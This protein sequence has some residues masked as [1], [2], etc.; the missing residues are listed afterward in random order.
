M[1][2]TKSERFF[3]ESQKYIPGGVNS[4]VRSFKAVEGI[5]PFLSKGK[6]SR[7]WDI[8]DNEYIDYVCSWGPLVLG[9]AHPKI[10]E[11]L[12]ETVCNGTS[13]GAPTTLE[14][15][16][17]KIICDALPSVDTI[18]L[19]SSGTEACM[20]AIR[21]AR[22]Y[23]GKNKLIK[24]SGCYHGHS[25]GLLVKAGSGAMTHGIPTS[26]GVPESYAQETLIAE[27]NDIESVESLFND[28]PGQIAGV[29]VEPVAGNMGVVLP[30][31]GFLPNL[32]K[33]TEHH[34]SMLIFDE[35]ITGFRVAYGGAQTLY[36]ITPDIT[37]LG[38]IIGGGLPVGA[39]SGK[40]EIMEQVAPLGPMYQAG[41]LSG[42]PLAVIAGI[43]TLTELKNPIIYS[44]IDS[45]AQRLTHGL[46]EISERIGIPCT[47]NRL[48]SMFTGF[49]NEGPVT[50]LSQV[51][52]SDTGRYGKY[53]HALLDRGVYMAPSQFE[54]GFVSAVHTEQDIDETLNLA[55]AAMKTLA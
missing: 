10:V 45:L 40:R 53:F 44:K 36:D 30:E 17:A 13:F 38:K 18:R 4:P 55:E 15:E 12:N 20:S 48:N 5:P 6:G 32:R 51:E 28:Y 2:Y 43:T 25:D 24:F 37:C 1:R 26:A 46:T 23:T 50:S 7:V 8:D 54:A 49:F 27:Y 29:I 35:V 21:L 16:L 52:T 14:L 11:A 9:H 39:Y 19:V 42:N 41:T 3:A 33:I 34:D 47:I 22:A 31:E